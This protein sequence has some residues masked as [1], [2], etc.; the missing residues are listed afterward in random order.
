MRRERLKDSAHQD[1]IFI[2]KG[3]MEEAEAAHE[4]AE[5]SLHHGRLFFLL[6]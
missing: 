5:A 4:V 1:L 3:L 6:S 2:L